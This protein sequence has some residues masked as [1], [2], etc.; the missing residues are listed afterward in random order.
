[1]TV[2]KNADA[3]F[4]QKLLDSV[5]R[6]AGILSEVCRGYLWFALNAHV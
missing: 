6:Q 2:T 5:R 4:K 3:D 1:V